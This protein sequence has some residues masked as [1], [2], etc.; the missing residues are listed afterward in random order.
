[1]KEQFRYIVQE[2][3]D[4]GAFRFDHSYSP[5]RSRTSSGRN[6]YIGDLL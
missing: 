4:N 3:R 2:W 6:L 1:M 5:I